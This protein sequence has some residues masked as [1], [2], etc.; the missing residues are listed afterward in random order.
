MSETIETRTIRRVSA[1][2]REPLISFNEILSGIGSLA[3]GAAVLAGK[4][5][6]VT[7]KVAFKGAVAAAQFTTAMLEEH[8]KHQLQG[9]SLKAVENAVHTQAGAAEALAELTRH[10]NFRVAL[11][12]MQ[13]LRQRIEAILAADDKPAVLMLA[14]ELVRTQQ[15]MIRASLAEITA[16][17]LR[18]MGFTPLKI[19]SVK[20]LVSGR[21]AGTRQQL[22]LEI[23]DDQ[24]GGVKAFFDADGFHGH[25]CH[26]SLE[27]LQR[28]MT[29]RG[30]D[31]EVVT[32]RTKHPARSGAADGSRMHLRQGS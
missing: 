10:E 23:R 32:R 31:F 25:A 13:P 11:T 29:S 5:A 21:K 4:A 19:D 28:E 9:C 2:P 1:P 18:A 6:R 26:E 22:S 12:Q 24:D 20:G 27:T 15:A 14:R 30:A 3:L 17:S 16:E 8:R 7:A